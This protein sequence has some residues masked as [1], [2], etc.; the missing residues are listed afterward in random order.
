MTQQ[1]MIDRLHGGPVPYRIVPGDKLQVMDLSMMPG[2]LRSLFNAD[3]F[4]VGGDEPEVV[5]AEHGIPETSEGVIAP[6]DK[7]ASAEPLK[8]SR[9][10]KG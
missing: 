4:F 1:E 7:S 6:R 3:G 2:A 9:E 10:A 8:Q 5:V